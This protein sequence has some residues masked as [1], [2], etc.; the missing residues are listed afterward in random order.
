MPLLEKLNGCQYQ[1]KD[2]TRDAGLQTGLLA[3]EVEKVLPELVKQT[4][5]A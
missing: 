3:Q 4:K 2:E 1:R 5:R